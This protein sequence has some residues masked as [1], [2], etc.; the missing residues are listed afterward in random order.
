MYSGGGKP[1]AATAFRTCCSAVHGLGRFREGLLRTAA[2][3]TVIVH[4]LQLRGA[5]L[6]A[7]GLCTAA[8][9]RFGT[10]A[11]YSVLF[12]VIVHAAKAAALLN[13]DDRQT[14]AAESVSNLPL[15]IPFRVSVY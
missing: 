9:L 13:N 1:R 10:A 7:R 12:C 8:A 4:L 2:V 6:A 5:A 3:A 11:A 15:S 14:H